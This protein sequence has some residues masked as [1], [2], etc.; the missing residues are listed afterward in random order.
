MQMSQWMLLLA[1]I[2]SSV[3]PTSVTNRGSQPSRT[4]AQVIR[5]TSNESITPPQLV[6]YN[7]PFYSDEAQKRGV[8]GI[9]TLEAAIGVDGIA[10]PLRVLK[11]LGFG[12]DENASLALREWRFVPAKRGEEAIET[13]V[14]IDIDFKQN[15][16]PSSELLMNVAPVGSVGSA[17][18]L[19]TRVNP[20]YSAEAA[21]SS[22]GRAVL[23][24][25]VILEDGSVRVV[26]LLEGL[27]SSLNESAIKA[28][29]QW[30]FTPALKDGKAVRIEMD[31]AVRI[32]QDKKP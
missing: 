16:S 29:E 28:I 17:P 9:V 26:R 21:A 6:S 5:M 8:E 11:G 14:Q 24:D 10:R 13:T 4:A 3:F 2:N 23:V 12:L 25:A 22:V 27:G 20:D 19:V 18:V 15:N 7:H 30:K 31:V 32:T 1:L